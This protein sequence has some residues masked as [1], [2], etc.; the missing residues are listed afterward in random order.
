MR[1]KNCKCDNS[2]CYKTQ[3]EKTQ[4]WE[5]NS[6]DK[7]VIGFTFILGLNSNC[8]N[9]QTVTKLEILQNLDF[10]E[11]PTVTSLNCEKFKL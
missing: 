6:F 11:A 4:L 9:T 3:N 5:N 10:D 1:K 2:K 8:E 7:T